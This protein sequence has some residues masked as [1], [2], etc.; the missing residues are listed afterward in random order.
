MTTHLLHG[1][2]IA[3]HFSH[4]HAHIDDELS[5]LLLRHCCIPCLLILPPQIFKVLLLLPAQRRVKRMQILRKG[6]SHASQ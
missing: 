4:F 5:F 3:H 6:G 2:R 1:H